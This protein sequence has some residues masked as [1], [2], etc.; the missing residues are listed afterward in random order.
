[1]LRGRPR[2]E[3]SVTDFDWVANHEETRWFLVMRLDKAP[4]DGLNQL[5]RISNGVV[6]SFGQPPLYADSQPPPQANNTRGHKIR[7]KGP[8]K[9]ASGSSSQ[10]SPA[11]M[12][13]LNHVDVSS[14]FHI[15]IGWTLTA[16]SKSLVEKLDS[17]SHDF[18]T[19]KID[20][21]TVKA[22]IGNGITSM[23]LASKID[24]SNRIIEK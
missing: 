6:Q 24:T 17:A 18:K 12:A 7:Q 4:Q 21:N 20:I 22:K 14:S 16:P 23:F 5:L 19:V 2:F 15:S 11:Q 9:T 10:A 1:M 8:L 13:A 3:V